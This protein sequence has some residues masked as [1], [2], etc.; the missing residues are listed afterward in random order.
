MS[1]EPG[2]T[3]TPPAQKI[4]SPIFGT[5]RSFLIKDGKGFSILN[6]N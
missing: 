5:S 3:I 1:I 2:S 6:K 4:I